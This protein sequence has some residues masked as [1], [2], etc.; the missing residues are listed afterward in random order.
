[1]MT[2]NTIHISSA[3]NVLIVP[4]ITITSRQG[5]HFVRILTD[6]NKVERRDVETGI[7]DGVFT[8]IRSGLSEGEQVISSEVSKGEQVGETSRMRRPRI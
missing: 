8:E 4:S 6:K 7:S 2:Q 3:K 1:M 5:K